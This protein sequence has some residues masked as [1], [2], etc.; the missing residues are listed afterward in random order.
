MSAVASFNNP[1]LVRNLPI[2]LIQFSPK[3][4]GWVILRKGKICCILGIKKKKILW[5]SICDSEPLFQNLFFCYCHNYFRF[6]ISV[7]NPVFTT[8][9]LI[10]LTPV[11]IFCYYVVGSFLFFCIPW[12]SFIMFC[13]I[14]FK[15]IKLAQKNWGTFCSQNCFSSPWPD[16]SV[17]DVWE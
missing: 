8:F 1:V 9:K 7:Q 14:Y 2:N 15:I 3:I 4:I 6:F 11:K 13:S 12:L 16:L 10:L 17:S 5:T